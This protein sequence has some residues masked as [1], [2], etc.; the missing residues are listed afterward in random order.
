MIKFG[1]NGA[2]GRM[3]RRLTALLNDQEDCALVCALEGEAH[4]DLGRDA[5]ELAGVG[6]LGVPLVEDMGR[7]ECL[8]DVVLDFSTPEATMVRVEQCAAAGVALAIGTTGLQKDDIE[9]VER[10]I[11]ARIPVLMSPNMSIGVSLLTQLLGRV[12]SA[13]GEDYDVEIVEMHH[14]RKTDAPSGTA[15]RFAEAICEAMSWDPGSAL[16]YGRKGPV[17]ERPTGGIAMHAVRGGDVVGDHT[18]IFAGAGERIEITHRA[19]TRDVFA[20]GAIRAGRFL[21][22]RGPGLYTMEQVL[23]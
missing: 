23:G 22:G 14:R 20:M 11:A 7:A 17:G 5:G 3:G 9:Y 4:A 6:A 18:V 1:V 12:A 10:E 16:V 8:P 15:L 2:A 13:L 21:A 19:S